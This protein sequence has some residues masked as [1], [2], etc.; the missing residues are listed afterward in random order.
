M[1]FVYINESQFT[2]DI[3]LLM[4][5]SLFPLSPLSHPGNLISKPCPSFGNKRMFKSQR[6]QPYPWPPNYQVTYLPQPSLHKPSSHCLETFPENPT[7]WIIRLLCVCVRMHVC[8]GVHESVCMCACT[9]I[10]GHFFSGKK[11]ARCLVHLLDLSSLQILVTRI[12]LQI[13]Q[14]KQKFYRTILCRWLV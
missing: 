11:D 13:V 4:T 8:V 6:T 10:I 7:V 1:V 3:W 12:C 14:L 2:L 5:L 9:F